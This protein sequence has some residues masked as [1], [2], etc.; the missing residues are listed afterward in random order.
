MDNEE[1][2]L[3]KSGREQ[4]W[5]WKRGGEGGI[6]PAAAPAARASPLPRA[7]GLGGW[8]KVLGI[9]QTS[10]AR[11]GKAGNLVLKWRSFL[12][13]WESLTE[14]MYQS[15]P[16]RFLSFL[17]HCHHLQS[18]TGTWPRN[19]GQDKGFWQPRVDI[20]YCPMWGF[21]VWLR[22]QKKSSINHFGLLSER[23]LVLFF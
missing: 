11:Q 6:S 3:L 12:G 13:G 7:A 19:T 18:C 20:K 4:N 21:I 8:C 5:V 14:P 1:K 2:W 10:T 16:K 15:W 22:W 23:D 17:K 9:L